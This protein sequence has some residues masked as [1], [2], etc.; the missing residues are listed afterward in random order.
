MSYCDYCRLLPDDDVNVIYHNEMYGFP[1]HDDVLLFERLVW[2][3]MQAGLN[4]TL[5]LQRKNAFQVAFENYDL[6]K[7]ALFED[8]EINRLM[9]NPQIIRHRK[10][11]EAVIFNAQAVLKIQKQWGSWNEWL[12]HHASLHSDLNDWVRLFKQHFRFV[13]SE[14]VREFLTSIAL[15]GHAHDDDCPIKQKIQ[16]IFQA[17]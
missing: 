3:I 17:A 15:F 11:I 13:G 16:K 1:L 5:I 6:S 8:K 9:K 2:E 7:L 12:C 10:K 14:I 4:W